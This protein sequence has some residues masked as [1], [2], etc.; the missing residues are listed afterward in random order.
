MDA[1]PCLGQ[2]AE[3]TTNRD[4]LIRALFDE[5]I[6]L[7]A[8]RDDR[9]TTRFSDNF[10]GY[11]GGG[12]FLVTSREEW[13]RIT[14]QDF[15][16]VPGRIRIEMRDLAL[17]DV[18]EKVVAVTA[19]FRIHLPHLPHLPAPDQILSRETAR[20]VLVFRLEGEQWMIAHSGISIPYYLVGAGEVYPLKGLRERNEELVAQVEATARALVQSETRFR[21]LIENLNDVLVVLRPDGV[22]SYLSPQWQDALGY[23]VSA[24]LGRSFIEFVHPDDRAACASA[25]QKV[26]G[27]PAGSIAARG[28][29]EFRV[30]GKDGAYK[31]YVT[32]VSR[33][34]DPVDDSISV[35]GI[36][37]DVTLTKQAD[38]ALKASE[39]RF[40]DM[41]NTTDGMVW[42]ADA[43]TFC[44]TFISQKAERLLG[45][46]TAD[47]LQPGFWVDHLHPDDKTW[48]PEFCASCTGRLEPHDFEYRFIAKD[49]R[50]VWLRDLVTVVAENGQP[51]WLRGVM[52][53]ITAKKQTEVELE[54]ARRMLDDAQ[55]LSRLGGWK[56]ERATGKV[57]WTQ[58]V[59]NIHGV[60][61]EFDPSEVTRDLAF[62]PPEDAATLAQAFQRALENG[63]AY[64]L[65][66]RL[67]RQDG[68][69]I[70]VRTLGDPQL[71]NGEVVAVTGN[72]MDITQRKQAE[73]EI[74]ALA[75]Y[76]PL[77][78]LPNR[79]LLF[80][81]L[82]IA[83]AACARR[84]LKGALLFIDLD[85]FKR[86]NDAF[87]HETGDLLL[88]EAARRLKTCVRQNDTV[89]RLGGDEFV[90][91]LEFLDRPEEDAA[92]DAAK[93]GAKILAS[94]GADYLLDGKIC[95][96]TPSIGVT[97]FDGAS[98][99]QQVLRQADHAMYRAKAE[100]RHAM[101]F[102]DPA[103]AV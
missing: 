80:D 3:M 32:N 41:V 93:V 48:A 90:V 20:L 21:S 23:E 15:A 49:G 27:A 47:W 5:Y 71:E 56:Y 12:D 59:Y 55:R 16:Q 92:T 42:E 18:S 82:K 84:Q 39:S 88:Q 86:I 14:R 65:E 35:V 95:R 91:M 33:V 77:T 50:T 52:V 46:S 100:G 53:D 70:W 7:Y 40:R 62:Y 67:V 58:E 76:D 61:P 96:S 79:R 38:A 69:V 19:F 22:F 97:V 57:K 26:I 81:R 17:Q 6:E 87:G 36:G 60:G 34:I 8:A 29:M 98:D 45:F 54:E 103:G 31:W 24:T 94:L 68:R 44:F 13:I 37:R 9:L 99:P 83:C 1:G 85:N 75:F 64:D 89:A 51:R 2:G 66:V 11:T 74:K 63:E 25:L 10:T 72:I 101:C 102:H 4:S 43:Q 30:R 28:S 73:D 78:H